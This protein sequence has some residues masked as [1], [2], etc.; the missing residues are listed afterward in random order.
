[1]KFKLD[2]NL[3]YQAANLFAKLG[4][5][6]ETVRQENLGGAPDS[7]IFETCIREQ[8]CLVTLDLD[9]ADIVRFP[10]E[11]TSGVAILR[12]PKGASVNILLALL[13][14]LLTAVRTQSVAGNLWIVE[15]GRIRVRE[16]RELG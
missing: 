16:S 11:A 1:M 3:G 15:P 2:E 4:H 9:F 7:I 14:T 13:S 5:R 10:P 12:L 6:V 8:S